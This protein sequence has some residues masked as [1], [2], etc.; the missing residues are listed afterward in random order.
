MKTFNYLDHI[1]DVKA[2]FKGEY[3]V[4]EGNFAAVYSIDSR[5][6]A[7]VCLAEGEHVALMEETVKSKV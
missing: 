6:V 4:A 1:G 2:S 3:I 7:C 5:M